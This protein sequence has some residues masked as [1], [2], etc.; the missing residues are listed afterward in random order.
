MR[1]TIGIAAL[2]IM[3]CGGSA[4]PHPAPE[5]V[6]VAAEVAEAVADRWL[7]GWGGSIMGDEMAEYAAERVK[8]EVPAAG[9]LEADGRVADGWL[10]GRIR[11]GMISMYDEV[12]CYRG[13]QRCEVIGDVFSVV[14][15]NVPPVMTDTFRVIVP[16]VLHIDIESESV[17]EWNHPNELPDDLP[18]VFPGGLPGGGLLP[19]STDHAERGN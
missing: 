14:S 18:V 17:V 8:E 10:A 7:V 3:A 15:V 6:D 12:R 2:A 16:F 11:A 1:W 9:Q 13:G 5:E 4:Q 19:W